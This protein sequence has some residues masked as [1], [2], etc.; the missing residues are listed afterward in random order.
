MPNNSTTAQLRAILTDTLG[1]FDAP[2]SFT[3]IL[4]HPLS[5]PG[6]ILSD[7]GP[8]IWAQLVLAACAATGGNQAVGLR[9]AVGVELF[10]AALDLLDEIEDGDH[11]PTAEAI[12]TAQTL[13]V[14]TA[15]LLLGQRSLLQLSTLTEQGESAEFVST[16]ISGGLVATGGQ[17]QD[18]ASVG[19]ALNS[20]DDALAITRRKAGTLAGAACRLGALTGTDNAT[21]LT[22]YE[23]WGNHFG[24]AAQ[25]SND[26]HDAADLG[27]KSDVERQK[28]TLPLVFGRHSES[29]AS[30]TLESGALHF[31]WVVLEIERQACRDIAEDLAARGQ[32]VEFLREMVRG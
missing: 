21:L 24:T 32:R 29:T 3:E 23:R 27:Q 14:A 13:N 28:G 9:V 7:T 5:Q 10:M 4:R 17:H 1:A 8:P 30:A 12:G 20:L 31:T 26:L 16:L 22:L 25:L 18:L 15:L 2:P 11:S 19:G 6:K